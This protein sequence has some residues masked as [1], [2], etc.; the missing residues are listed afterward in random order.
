VFGVNLGELWE[1]MDRVRAWM[2]ALLAYYQE[3]AI[4]PVV[5]ASFPFE[6]AAQAHPYIQDRKNLGKVLLAP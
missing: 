2:E 6:R 5:A 4:R 3:G 1:E